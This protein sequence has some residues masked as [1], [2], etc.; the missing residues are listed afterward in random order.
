MGERGRGVRDERIGEAG[1]I[2]EIET[3]EMTTMTFDIIMHLG[4]CCPWVGLVWQRAWQALFYPLDWDTGFGMQSWVLSLIF[5]TLLPSIFSL[6]A[7]R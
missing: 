6:P 4:C 5:S 1:L 3:T 2:D 7:E